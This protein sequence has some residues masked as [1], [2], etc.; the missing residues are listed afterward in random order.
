MT[1]SHPDA[2]DKQWLS[3][4]GL[5][6][7]EQAVLQAWTE[8]DGL[9]HLN[10]SLFEELLMAVNDD[11][12]RPLAKHGVP[13]IVVNG[14]IAKLKHLPEM[15][16]R[17][18]DSVSNLEHSVSNLQH[19][20][21]KLEGNVQV[22]ADDLGTVKEHVQVFSRSANMLMFPFKQYFRPVDIGRES[23]GSNKSFRVKLRTAYKAESEDAE[24]ARG[25]K[26]A[27]AMKCMVLNTLLP[28]KFVVAGH[29]FALRWEDLQGY[30]MGPGFKINDARNGVLWNS[31]V[32]TVYEQQLI[33]FSYTR[34]G[35]RF[36]LHVLDK[37]LMN[38]KLA[39]VGQHRY[40]STAQEAMCAL[41]HA[42]EYPSDFK[43][44]PSICDYGS[45]YD[46]KEDFIKMWLNQ[47]P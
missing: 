6:E 13:K 4:L 24:K 3:T 25:T 19:S 37:G 5:K 31:S 44:S 41:D 8:D 17:L 21:S 42:K 23:R 22:M 43:P 27:I 40:G 46:G 34:E 38:K 15:V 18:Q 11:V 2:E 1:S 28:T 16:R 47:L 20:V 39:D 26:P 30:T 29:L 36:K 32:E 9:G 10:A 35:H 14:L 12:T 45:D 7:H 33:C